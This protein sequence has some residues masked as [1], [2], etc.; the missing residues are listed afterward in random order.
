MYMPRQIAS[1]LRRGVTARAPSALSTLSALTLAAASLAA[2]VDRSPTGVASPPP[3]PAEARLAALDCEVDVRAGAMACAPA[4]AAGPNERV[5]RGSAPAAGGPR[6]DLTIGGQNTY[7]RLAT[8]G[9][10]TRDEA[11]GIVSGAVTVANLTG[12][13]MGTADGS[14]VSGVR[15]FF[16][17]PP[18]V[19]DGTGTVEVANPDGF[20]TFTG[21]NQPYHLYAQIVA[22]NATS[23]P[24]T[25]QFR[26]PATV[27]RYVFQVYVYAALPLD[28]VA[29]RWTVRNGVAVTSNLWGVW[30]SASGGAYAVG[31]SGTIMRAGPSGWVPEISGSTAELRGVWGTAM[32]DAYA[33]GWSSTILH[34]TAA[35]WTSEAVPP[36]AG[37]TSLYGVWGSGPDDVYAVGVATGLRPVILRRAGGTWA[38]VAIAGSGTLSSVW[39]S[40]PSDVYAVGFG[41]ALH[42]DGAAWSPVAGLPSDAWWRAVSGSGPND[43]YLAGDYG[44]YRFDGST[45]TSLGRPATTLGGSVQALYATSPTSVLAAV[46]VEPS[47]LT[48]GSAFEWNGSRWT[49]LTPRPTRGLFGVNRGIFVGGGSTIMSGGGGGLYNS[50][51][52]LSTSLYGIYGSSAAEVFAVGSTAKALWLGGSSLWDPTTC[53]RQEAAGAPMVYYQLRA[54]TPDGRMYAAVD[55]IVRTYT[56]IPPPS[57]TKPSGTCEKVYPPA[58]SPYSNSYYGATAAGPDTIFVGYGGSIVRWAGTSGSIEPSGTTAGLYDVQPIGGTFYAVGDGGTVLVRNAAT[59]S[60]SRVTVPTTAALNALWG[61][62]A[63]NI[64]VVGANGTILHRSAAGWAVMESGTTS[65]LGGVWGS[66]PADVYAVGGEGTI[67]HYDGLRWTRLTSGTTGWL[68]AVWGS[69]PADVHVVGLDGVVLRGTR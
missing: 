48:P 8:A 42:F 22:P 31:S 60:W 63:D 28:P 26:V 12:L 20:G 47:P 10:Q 30:A 32:D 2:C 51:T 9:P 7:I 37:G 56:P 67:V 3:P 49:E 1:R 41:I 43:V 27:V 58:G 24:K 59:Q 52:R 18:T 15:V 40:G 29:A 68:T 17:Q 46:G 55:G 13:P 25:W 11:T 61:T 45:W 36:E 38:A 4:A 33:V 21:S 62:A 69:G 44:F 39:G 35:G 19:V 64:W 54:A 50:Y 53:W 34:R 5:P 14:T 23:A 66:G 57:P 65:T 16:H 6:L